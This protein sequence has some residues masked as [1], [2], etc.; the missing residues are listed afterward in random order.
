M[1]KIASYQIWMHKISIQS[2]ISLSTQIGMSTDNNAE[3]VKAVVV[4][5][6]SFLVVGKVSYRNSAK[7]KFCSDTQNDAFFHIFQHLGDFFFFSGFQL[8]TYLSTN[9]N[10]A[11]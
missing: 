7:K 9:D 6:E 1:A 4:A 5:L 2:L 11:K 3:M 10:K 8:S